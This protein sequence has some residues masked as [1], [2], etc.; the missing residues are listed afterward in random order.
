MAFILNA[1]PSSYINR[2]MAEVK[3]RLVPFPDLGDLNEEDIS[4][5]PAPVKKYLYYTGS[6][7]KPKIRNFRA[8][9]AGS[10]KQKPGGGWMKIHS[11]QYN[12]FDD[13]ARLFYIKASMFGIPFDGL[14]QYTGNHATMQIKVANLITVVDASGEKMDQGE[15]VT[16]FNDMCLMAPATL[17]D[18]GIT[19]REIDD[20]TV[21]AR[22][23]NGNHTIVATLYF[24]ESGAMT[25]FISND[26]FLSSDGKTYLNYPWSTPVKVWNEV[27][28]RKVPTS[29]EAIWQTP[30]GPFCYGRFEIGEIEYNMVE[31]R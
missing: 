3:S 19:W 10:M 15:T 25:N 4:H 6:V 20:I 8:V 26:R 29:G 21:E 31:F 7:G 2:Y 9:F 17:I 13:P 11:Q 27:H 16:M 30:E 22:F 1:L 12:F 18:T 14:H 28:G 24:N 23:T 5:L